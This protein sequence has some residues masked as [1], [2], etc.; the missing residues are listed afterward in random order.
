VWI[1]SSQVETGIFISGTS[2]LDWSANGRTQRRYGNR[3]PHKPA[4]PHGAFRCRGVQSSMFKVQSG[5]AEPLNVERGTLNLEDR[6]IAIACF[7][8]GEWRALTEVAGKPEWREDP[9]FATLE[10]RLAYQDALEAAVGA[11][12]ATQADYPLMHALQEAGVPAGVCQTAEDRYE[13]DP[14]LA[15]L[16]WLVEVTG[17]EI[18]TWPVR[19]IPVKMSATPPYIG[20]AIDRG[21]PC[22]GED[23]EY[24]L[25]EILG[26]PSGEIATLKADGVV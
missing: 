21:G 15:A 13:H 17:T 12:T 19:E 14:Q 1:D 4:A 18:G 16:A 5:G 7:T 25:G 22:Y 23:N 3:S 24:V 2:V 10:A 26:M 9:R 11:W 6:W 20:G 8:E